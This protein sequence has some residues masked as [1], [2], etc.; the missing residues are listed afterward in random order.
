[1]VSCL[2]KK[3]IKAIGKKAFEKND[4]NEIILVDSSGDFGEFSLPKN[5]TKDQF[6]DDCVPQY[7]LPAV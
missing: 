5:L 7:F 4:N 6:S 1:M 3:Q 2:M